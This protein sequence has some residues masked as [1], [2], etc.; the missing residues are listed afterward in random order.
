MKVD[1]VLEEMSNASDSAD[2]QDDN[3]MTA[4]AIMTQHDVVIV[5]LFILLG[6]IMITV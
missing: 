2:G 3:A 4:S 1:D 5:L 6:L